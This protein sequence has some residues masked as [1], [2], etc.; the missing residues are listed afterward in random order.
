MREKVKMFSKVDWTTQVELTG[1]SLQQQSVSEGFI[2]EHNRSHSEFAVFLC[3]L[4]QIT[5]CVCGKN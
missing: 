1:W 3:T 2:V 4:E 5:A